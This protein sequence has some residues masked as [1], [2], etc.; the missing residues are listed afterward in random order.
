VE[1]RRAIGAR[2]GLDPER[3]VC[4]TGSD[5]LIGHLC[6]IYGGPGTELIMTRHGFAMY[7]IFGTYAGCRV[8]QTPERHLTADVDAILA[9]V[10][11]VTRIVCLANPNNPTGS[12]LPRA[13]VE[14][15]RRG[16]PPDVLLVLDAAY[17]EFVADPDYDPGVG[18]VDAGDDTVM[19]RTFSKVFGLGGLRVGWAY[20]PPAVV[21]ALNRV[22]G[23]FNV[24]GVAQAAAVAALADTDWV[25]RNVSH[26]LE[27]RVRLSDSLTRAGITVWPSEGNFV[28]ADLGTAER[29]GAA[30]QFLRARGIIVRAMGGYHLPHC[31]RI[32][33]GTAEECAMVAETLTDFMAGAPPT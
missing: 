6:L 15:L 13:E 5:E 22:R 32:T 3:I 30:N 21:D 4:G 25:A 33:I 16:L 11:P 26:V 9:A 27:W 23:A 31:L 29:A 17:A 7:E 10:S 18:M 1:L 28:L 12:L 14:R 8:V 19:L 2:F 20:A 24:N